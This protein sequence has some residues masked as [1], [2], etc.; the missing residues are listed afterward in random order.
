MPDELTSAQR[1]AA[2]HSGGALLIAAAAGSGKTR[3]L[4]ERL[5]SRVTAPDGP[6][7][8]DFLVIT[9]TRAAAA[10]LRE[11]ISGELVKRLAD[12][13]SS[14]R[15]RRQLALVSRA[16]ISTIDAFC[17]EIVRA[18]AHLLGIRPDFRVADEGESSVIHARVMDRLLEERYSAMT[19][20]FRALAETMNTGKDDEKLETTIE[21]TYGALQSHAY[22]RRWIEEHLGAY[23]GAKD[24][25]ETPWGEALI[26]YAKRRNSAALRR[27][28]EARTLVACDGNAEKQYGPGF[29]D[30]IEDMQAYGEAL[31]KGWD[32]VRAFGGVRFKIGTVRGE[33]SPEIAAAKRSWDACRAVHKKLAELFAAPSSVVLAEMEKTCVVT[34]E[35]LRVVRDYSD[36]LDEEKKHKNVLEFGDILHLAVRL[37]IDDDGRPTPRALDIAGGFAEIL[38]DEYQ[39]VSDVQDMIF[40]AISKDGKNLVFVGDVKQSIYRFRLADPTIFLT[41]YNAWKDA[42]APG[43]PRRILLSQNFRS[44]QGVLDAVNDVFSRIMSVELGEMEYGEN[45]ALWGSGAPDEDPEKPFE[46]LLLDTQVKDEDEETREAE[47]SAVAA[48]IRRLLDSGMTVDGRP[49]EPGDIAVLMRFMKSP[50]GEI[51]AAALRREGVP[52]VIQ[53]D[54]APDEPAVSAVLSYLAVI[55]NPRQDVELIAVLR[56]PLFGFTSDE[57]AAIRAADRE[58]DFYSALSVRAREDAK[59]ADFM[60][61]LLKLREAAP[62]LGLERLLRLI[63]DESGILAASGT[64]GLYALLDAA[65]AFESRGGAGLYG[66]V[67]ELRDMEEAGKPFSL[68]TSQRTSGGVTLCTMHASKGLE[69]P[70]VVLADLP[71]RYEDRDG[72]KPILIHS[73]LGV[74][75][76]YVDLERR[77][78]YPT[79]ARLAV[80]ARLKNESL[81]EEMR[82][83]YVA[84]TRAKKKLII[85]TAPYSGVK[86]WEKLLSEADG[87]D[88]ALL[89]D[90][91]N[92]TDWLLLVAAELA[93]CDP[94]WVP[95]IVEPAASGGVDAP[96]EPGQADAALAELISE[97][98][99]F[100][101]PYPEAWKIPSKLTATEL[102]GGVLESEAAEGADTY[103]RRE[104]AN[105]R[106]PVFESEGGRLSPTERGT[107]LHK[108]VQFADLALCV[109][110]DGARAE[111]ERLRERHMLTNAEADSVK[112]EAIAA[113]AGSPLGK[114]MLAAK[115]LRRE[116]KFSLLIPAGELLDGAGEDELLLQGVVDCLFDEGDGLVIVDFKSDNVTKMT[117]PAAARRYAPQL[118]AYAKA[119]ER[120]FER[121]VAQK[122][123][124]FFR[125][126][127]AVE[128]K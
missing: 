75:I 72:K 119:M 24:A 18:N 37:L 67:S 50:R 45:E 118:G 65:R 73:D 84:M 11:R 113:L 96:P 82:L 93:G 41:K 92:M 110:A 117:Q 8:D 107:A 17:S 77:I 124:Y 104:P 106:R 29:D 53:K 32:A 69:W 87:F 116:F 78:K 60:D 120:I 19:P 9:F 10:E 121:P 7:I 25:S 105:L 43:E 31:D 64:G 86:K 55:D 79:I 21:T 4:V 101:P 112:P 90:R 2:E 20:A 100:A 111:I 57:L 54:E 125:T 89:E 47:A 26:A 14:R 108:A 59:C 5:M 13:P 30:A 85:M 16:H 74:G 83:L 66:F 128:I 70:V 40:R 102:K 97:R 61:K 126:G 88:P 127:E 103:V 63:Y 1:A 34:D 23:R 51:Y 114:R 27:L 62:E 109:T 28:S 52:V 99:D 56:S 122:L 38:V 33:K 71:N 81:S 42:P 68:P 35:L 12:E 76:D 44:R 58:G 94:K 46:L 6:D 36:A 91:G 3:V 95:E 22:P 123:L 48:R 115:E 49:I 98:L 80:R 39:D 15:L